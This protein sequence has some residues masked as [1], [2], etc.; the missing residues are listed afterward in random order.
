MTKVRSDFN[1]DYTETNGGPPMTWVRF[2]DQFHD[3]PDLYEFDLSGDAVC[4]HVCGTT[5]CAAN[6]T[7]GRIPI[8]KVSKLHRGENVAA[9]QEL[10]RAGWWVETDGAYIIRS[11]L[12][13][14]KS[15]EQVL[16]ER[17]ATQKRVDK[18]RNGSPSNGVTDGVGNGGCNGVTH[19]VTHTVGNGACNTAPVPVPVPVPI[20]VPEEERTPLTPPG[21]LGAEGVTKGSPKRFAPPS[22][23][24]VEEYFEAYDKGVP[25]PNEAEE[26]W[27]YWESVGWRTKS[28]P[29]KDWKAAA[30]NNRL[31]RSP[32]GRF[33]R[34]LAQSD[35]PPARKTL[36]QSPA[37]PGWGGVIT[38]DDLASIRRNVFMGVLDDE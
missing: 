30:R 27:N 24:E 19:A 13:Y 1:H 12:K 17:V 32:G 11:F 4:I 31:D 10:V 6:L 22:L 2:D 29:M 25:R 18:W 7:D 34:P 21:G 8:G 5:W 26:F 14:N 38:E 16:G 23:F 35:R 28:G 9:V 36:G 37:I 3:D 33:Y 20:P 15:R